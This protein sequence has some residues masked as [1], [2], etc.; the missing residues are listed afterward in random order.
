MCDALGLHMSLEGVCRTNNWSIIVTE[1]AT[2]GQVR[3]SHLGG[4]E[5]TGERDTREQNNG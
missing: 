2:L 5:R 1:V 3:T 4:H